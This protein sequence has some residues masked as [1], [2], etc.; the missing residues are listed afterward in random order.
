MALTSLLIL[1]IVIGLIFWALSQIPMPAP[2]RT[3]ATVIM[4]IIAIAM[5]L[6]YVQVPVF[7]V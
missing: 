6:G 4:V 5:L 7:R 3:I 1:V 2:W